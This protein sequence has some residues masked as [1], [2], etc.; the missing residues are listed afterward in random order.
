MNPSPSRPL[1]NRIASLLL[2]WNARLDQSVFT[3]SNQVW[4]CSIFSSPAAINAG[5]LVINDPI[6]GCLKST[7]AMCLN[8]KEG[9][10]RYLRQQG[11]QAMVLIQKTRMAMASTSDTRLNRMM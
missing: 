1:L 6:A 11:Q 8:L 7:L 9:V 2:I 4:F 5:I 10:F 3:P